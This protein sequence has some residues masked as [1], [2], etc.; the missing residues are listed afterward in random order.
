MSSE[1]SPDT[2]F[3]LLNLKFKQKK[4]NWEHFLDNKYPTMLLKNIMCDIKK[5]EN[6]SKKFDTLFSQ[7]K[8][9]AHN[10]DD[11]IRALSISEKY[12]LDY[13]AGLLFNM[14][15]L[16]FDLKNDNWALF[17]NGNVPTM[18]LMNIMNY[19]NSK[20]DMTVWSLF[21]IVFPRYVNKMSNN[22]IIKVLRFT[23]ASV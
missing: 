5:N 20:E 9:D 22:N 19:I 18:L 16:E 13:W 12:A 14:L 2:L 10:C 1:I 11:I 6:D 15:I 7:Y 3:S 21:Y 23:G 17:L 4:Y 8:K